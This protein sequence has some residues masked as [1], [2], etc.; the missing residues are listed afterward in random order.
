LPGG[1]TSALP[2]TSEEIGYACHLV[3][4]ELPE[5]PYLPELPHRGP[6]ADILGRGALF[7]TDMHVDLQPAGW[8]IVSR[9]GH[10]ERRGRDLLDRDLD[11]LEE[12]A[13][14]YAGPLKVQVAGPWTLA[15]SLEL[16]RGDKVLRDAGA[17]RDVAEALADGVAGHVADVRRR[18]PG[19]QVL[20]ALD[21]PLLPAVLRGRLP[22]A[23]GFGRLPQPESWL[24]EQR[25]AAVLRGVGA[26]AGVH[27]CASD[28]PVGVARRAGAAFVSLDFTLPYD[29]DDV[30]E[31]VEAGVGLIAGLVPTAEGPSVLSDVR[32][33]VEPVLSLWRRLGLAAEQLREVAVSPTCGLAG[34]SPDGALA[35]FRRCREAGGRLAEGEL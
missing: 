33:T 23:S 25:L 27:C 30:G 17:V 34:V 28:P 1:F 15:A 12:V 20:V 24:A 11:A 35:A 29:E 19:A 14:D 22:T 13:V 5:L 6:G 16:T 4:E 26:P 2:G 31:A 9:P 3:F 32:R 18:V 21:E 7:L 10:D 8:R